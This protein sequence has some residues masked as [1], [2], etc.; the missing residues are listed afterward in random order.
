MRFP[1]SPGYGGKSRPSASRPSLTQWT[2]LAMDNVPSFDQEPILPA[3][4]FDTALRAEEEDV[5]PAPRKESVG[6]DACDLIDRGFELT[7]LG[8]LEVVDVQNAVAIVGDES[9]TPF[10]LA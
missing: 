1:S 4:R 5:R 3:V 9:L 6:H 7:R 2:V 8:D 10:G